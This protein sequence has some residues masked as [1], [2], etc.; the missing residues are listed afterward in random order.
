[1]IST[2]SGS[3]GFCVQAT[4]QRRSGQPSPYAQLK[5]LGK[6]VELWEASLVAQERICLQ[7]GDL[8]SIPGMGRSPGEGTGYPLKD[9][10]L[11]NSMGCIIHGIAK[12]QT[13]LRECLMLGILIQSRNTFG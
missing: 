4:H 6:A 10:G 1:M 7:C 11:E 12:S 8:G 9:S 2:V 13:R 3:S 5:Y